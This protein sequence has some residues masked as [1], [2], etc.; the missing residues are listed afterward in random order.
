[1]RRRE[2]PLDMDGEYMDWLI[3]KLHR[4]SRKQLALNNTNI[5]NTV[6]RHTSQ[7]KELM[8][9]IVPG[10]PNDGLYTNMIFS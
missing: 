8:Q 5:T 9:H 10:R 6:Q 1:M 4:W 7:Y 3:L 2:N